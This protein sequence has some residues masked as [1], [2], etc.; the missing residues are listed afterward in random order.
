MEKKKV[1]FNSAMVFAAVVYVGVVAS[2]TTIFIS[3]V[4][5]AFPEDAYLSRV[6]MLLAGVLV[7]CS[8]LAFPVALHTWTFEKNHRIWTTVFYYGEMAVIAVNT[9][10]SFM[11]LLEKYSNYTA[12]DWAALYEP[13]SVGAIVYTLFAW[14]T[15]FLVD[16]T[17]RRIAQDRALEE[18]FENKVS[19][20]RNEFLD[21]VEG[22]DAIARA[23][24]SDI[25]A[26]FARGRNEKKHFGSGRI[27]APVI[28]ERKE[29]VSPLEEVGGD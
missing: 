28:F 17:H 20:K 14:G 5:S 21:T 26:F 1:E 11:V 13:F 8:M 9:V 23:A 18:A 15:V 16:P 27:P 10:V 19:A 25:N 6:V 7:G 24:E 3:F 22:E 12:P 4:L 29:S 2:V